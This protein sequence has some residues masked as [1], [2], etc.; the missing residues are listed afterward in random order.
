MNRTCIGCRAVGA[1]ESLVRL[2][3][4]PSGEV[5]FDLAGRSFGR[6][7]WVHPQPSCLLQAARGGVDRAFRQ[8]FGLDGPSFFENFR[9][10]AHRR[11]LALVSA[12]RRAQKL[13][14]GSEAVAEASA[15]G[16]VELLILAKDARAAATHA[17]LEPLIAAGRVQGFATKAELGACL[18]RTETA[19][20]AVTDA[21]LAREIKKSIEWTELPE[22]KAASGRAA[23]TIS[24]EAG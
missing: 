3:A 1:P 8:A 4:G 5:L 19:I 21:R 14:A 13:E 18:T 15:R 12:A 20:V 11:A 17:F 6:G 2:F 16:R 7:A 10:T 23:R 22:P 9:Q 24:S